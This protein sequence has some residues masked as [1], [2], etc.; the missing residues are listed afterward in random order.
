MFTNY[1]PRLIN[2]FPQFWFLSLLIN[3]IKLLSC[4]LDLLM[5]SLSL[6]PFIKL[7]PYIILKNWI[8]TGSKTI[9]THLHPAVSKQKLPREFWW[10]HSNSWMIQYS[11]ARGWKQQLP[12]EFLWFQLISGMNLCS[13]SSSFWTSLCRQDHSVETKFTTIIN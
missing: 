12:L 13:P 8:K 11:W 3:S 6:F 7:L 4:Y 9:Q 5:C 1:F 10:L 2:Q